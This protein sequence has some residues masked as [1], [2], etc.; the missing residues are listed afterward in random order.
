MSEK[1][2]WNDS[3]LLGIPEIDNQHKKLLELA[4]DLH[5]AAAGSEENYKLNMSKVLKKLTDYTVYHFSNEEDF[6]RKYGYAGVDIHKTA[7]DNFIGEVNHQNNQ[8]SDDKKEDGMRFYS[9]MVNWVLTHIA[10]ADKIWAAYV[11]TKL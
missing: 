4:N 7:H 2:E 5:E 1:I 3:Y 9:Y 6:M 10:K 8:L 11:K